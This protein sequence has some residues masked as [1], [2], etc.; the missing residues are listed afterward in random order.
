M[1]VGHWSFWLGCQQGAYPYLDCGK[2]LT[3]RF[4]PPC[5][6]Q[7]KAD[8]DVSHL[9]PGGSCTVRTV[10]GAGARDTLKPS[11]GFP[12]CMGRQHF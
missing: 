6:P 1:P 3:L 12:R 9:V 2:W 11:P 5:P 4:P 8:S 7:L 10:K